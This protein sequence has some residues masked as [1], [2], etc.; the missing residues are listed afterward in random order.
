MMG[1][2]VPFDD[3]PESACR[4]GASRFSFTGRLAEMVATPANRRDAPAPA[5]RRAVR[6]WTSRGE[7]ALP[8]D[9]CT[10]TSRSRKGFDETGIVDLSRLE[11]NG[12]PPRQ[13]FQV[14]SNP[15]G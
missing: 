6:R 12:E 15:S 5:G 8:V 10:V 3:H 13:S 7:D 1:S 11:E 9:A 4:L 2:A 14:F